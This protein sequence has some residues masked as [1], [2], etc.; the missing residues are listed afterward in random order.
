MKVEIIDRDAFGSIKPL[1]LNRYLVANGWSEVRR[2]D[3]RL[4][5]LARPTDKEKLNLCG[6]RLVTNIPTM[7]RWLPD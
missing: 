4:L 2:I 6:C 7:Y 3:G 5:S 1:A